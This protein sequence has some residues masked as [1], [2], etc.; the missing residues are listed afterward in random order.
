MLRGDE[1]WRWPQVLLLQLLLMIKLL[2]GSEMLMEPA[3]KGGGR[4]ILR[5]LVISYKV[6]EQLQTLLLLK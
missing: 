1:G 6:R 5:L 4:L 2:G 3:Q